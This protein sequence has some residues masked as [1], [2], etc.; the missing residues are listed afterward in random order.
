MNASVAPI[1]LATSI[2]SRC[3]RICRRMVLKVT[4]TRPAPSS[5][6]SSQSAEPRDRAAARPGAA[7]TR[8]GLHV[9]RRPGSLRELARSASSVS[10]AVDVTTKASGSGLRP[11]APITSARPCTALISFSASSRGTKRTLAMRRSARSALPERLGVGALRLRREEQRDAAAR[12]RA[13]RR[14]R[15]GSRAA[16]SRPRAARARCRSPAHSAG[17]SL[18]E[19]P[20]ADERLHGAGAARRSCDRARLPARST[21]LP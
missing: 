19:P 9:R 20:S 8:V 10:V 2:S 4:A 5:A 14:R 13:A 15:A 3:V 12:A 11:S 6:A 1:S 17:S 18:R 7:P 16:R 21:R